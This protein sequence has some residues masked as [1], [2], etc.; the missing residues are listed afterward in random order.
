MDFN[1][2]FN[3]DLRLLH[4]RL[5]D[6]NFLT[7]RM[8]KRIASGH[9]GNLQMDGG[10]TVTY[11]YIMQL[12]MVPIYRYMQTSYNRD[13]ITLDEWSYITNNSNM[14]IVHFGKE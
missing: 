12:H 4:V 3:K 2:H 6:D 1:Q 8:N 5:V 9:E 10:K 14:G 11:K 13:Q 7:F